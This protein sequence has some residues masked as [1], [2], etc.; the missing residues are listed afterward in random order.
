MAKIYLDKYVP[1]VWKLY[2]DQTEEAV[3]GGALS[4]KI[5][6]LMAAA[7]AIAS[8]CE[9]CVKL[10]IRRAVKAGA[11]AREI[12]EMAGVV[13]MLGGGVAEIWARKIIDL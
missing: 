10:H 8:H 5:K 9:P 2:L 1:R 13:V 12:S 6:E 4:N 11:N 3:K 7:V